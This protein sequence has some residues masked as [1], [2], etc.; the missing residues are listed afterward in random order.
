MMILWTNE[1]LIKREIT[2]QVGT[3]LAS[4]LSELLDAR[5]E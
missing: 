5:R 1:P 2:R 4:A 3:A